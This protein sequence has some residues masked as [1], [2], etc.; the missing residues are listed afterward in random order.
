MFTRYVL[1][2]VAVATLTFAA[3][4]VVRAQQKPEPVTPPIEPGKSP[5]VKQLAGA[6]IVEPET[7]NIAVGSFTPGVVD[8]VLVKVGHKVRPG[9]PLFQLDDRALRAELRVRKA[10]LTSAEQS[11]AKLRQTPRADE[12]PTQEAKVREA[13]VGVQNSTQQY[14]RTKALP[15]GARSEEELVNREMG[16][17]LAKATLARVRAE[18]KL[19]EAGA[20][21]ADKD[22]AEAAVT[23]ARAQVEQT[24][25][26]LTRLTVPAPQLRWKTNPAGQP[27]PDTDGVEFEVLQVNVRP[28]E[29]VNAAA[30]NALVVLGA[31]G[32]MHVRV[33][34]DENDIARFRPDLTGVAKPRGNPDVSFPLT[35]VRLEPYVIPKKSLTGSNTERVDTRVLQVIYAVDMQGRRMYVG[36]QMDVFLNAGP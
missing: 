9:D 12:R 14:N 21:Q 4:Q 29:Y 22:I 13:E 19:W 17:E 18:F 27:L 33:D 30:G 28:G 35:F 26:E 1:P 6:G 16:V 24:E 2:V 20:W 11:L 3:L 34:L 15:T 5:F 10:L 25:T 36:Q 32:R 8:K 7:E 31:V 23:Q